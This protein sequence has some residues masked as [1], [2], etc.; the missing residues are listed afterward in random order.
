[1]IAALF[2]T[3]IDWAVLVGYFIGIMLL[4]LFFWRRNRS[5]DEFTAGGGTLP[6]WLL[7]MSIFATFLSSISYLALPGKAFVANWNAFMYSLAL[8]IAALISVK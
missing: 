8:P 5:V 1:M 7:G 2:F 3:G 4:G 6:G